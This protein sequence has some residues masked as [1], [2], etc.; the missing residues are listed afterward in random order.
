M[1]AL[2]IVVGVPCRGRAAGVAQQREQV[3]VEALVPHPSV[4][5]FDQA[6][7]HGFAG[8]DVV[9]ADLVVLLPFQHTVRRLFRDGFRDHPAGI[10]T[11]LGDAIQLTGD[12]RRR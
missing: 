3:F 11:Q 5:V 10:A 4:D 12:T 9:P 6:V 7:L 1:W 8:R 2:V